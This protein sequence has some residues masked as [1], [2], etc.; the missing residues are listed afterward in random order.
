MEYQMGGF[1]NKKNEVDVTASSNQMQMELAEKHNQDL[2][3]FI[4]TKAEE[5][6]VIVNA[7]P[8][9]LEEYQTS[10]EEV[11]KKIEPLLYH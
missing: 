7:H 9:F 6:R 3:D 10:P 1:E 5:F 4:D 2:S 8:E 11:L